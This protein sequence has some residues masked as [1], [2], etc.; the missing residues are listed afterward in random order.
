MHISDWQRKL[1]GFGCDGASVNIA[2][3]GLR[4]CLK[5][6]PSDVWHTA[7]NLLQKMS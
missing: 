7:W 6:T 5:G 3:N 4:E 1:V 2:P